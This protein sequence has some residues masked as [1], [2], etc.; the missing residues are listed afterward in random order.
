MRFPFAFRVYTYIY[1]LICL[2]VLCEWKKKH[3]DNM[4]LYGSYGRNPFDLAIAIVELTV[5]VQLQDEINNNR[6]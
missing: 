2:L 5:R 4:G 3:V 1:M 6:M